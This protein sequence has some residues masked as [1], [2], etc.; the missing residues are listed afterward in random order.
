MILINKIL[1]LLTITLQY[2]CVVC[3]I[4]ICVNGRYSLLITQ[5]FISYCFGKTI[6]NRRREVFLRQVGKIFLRY[7]NRERNLALCSQIFRNE[8]IQICK[9]RKLFC[10]FFSCFKHF[11]Q[12]ISITNSHHLFS[13]YH[14][15]FLSHQ[16]HLMLTFL[17]LFLSFLL[18]FYENFHSYFLEE[19]PL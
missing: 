15:M 11:I 2:A 3:C 5:N 10:T 17:N 13:Q 6:Y 1:I 12:K 8:K 16:L 9:G 14:H 4:V 18:R 7:L 19:I